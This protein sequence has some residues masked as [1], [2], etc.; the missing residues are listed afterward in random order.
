MYM[1]VFI[2]TY[3][4]QMNFADSDEMFLHLSARGAV[5]TDRLED[6]DAV[7]EALKED[8]DSWDQLMEE[9]NEDTG[10]QAGAPNAEKGYA[11]CENMSGFDS[12]FVDAAMAL[13]SVGDV[14]GKVRGETYGYYIIKYVSDET[15]GP[16]DYDSV[17]DALH[18]SL[19]TTKQNDTYNAAID[20]WVAESGIKVDLGALNN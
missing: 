7:L 9:K 6:A 5:R 11:V 2:E 4:C 20:Q 19:L 15:E 17:K 10:L 1:K 14:S 3:G 18:D 12:A 13:G 8:P 16:V